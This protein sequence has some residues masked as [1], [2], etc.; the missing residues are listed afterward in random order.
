VN[1]GTNVWGGFR[2]SPDGAYFY[3]TDY[4]NDQVLVFD[5][6]KLAFGRDALLTAIGAPYYPYT[7]DVGAAAPP[8][9][10]ATAK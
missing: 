5:G 4:R 10:P 8:R 1:P 2:V 6:A 3:A 7:I 9:R